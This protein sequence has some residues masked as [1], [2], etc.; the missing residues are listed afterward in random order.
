MIFFTPSLRI[1]AELLDKKCC[2][3]ATSNSD[4]LELLE[5]SNI[6]QPFTVHCSFGIQKFK[7]K[8][9]QDGPWP[10]ASEDGAPNNFYEISNGIY[11][12]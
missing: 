8:M 4:D 7:T 3:S 2:K 5:I 11:S 1:K 12:P 10:I 9:M 6:L